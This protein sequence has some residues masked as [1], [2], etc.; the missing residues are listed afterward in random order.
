M[1]PKLHFTV[2]CKYRMVNNYYLDQRRLWNLKHLSESGQLDD[3]DAQTYFW[4]QATAMYVHSLL[5]KTIF[6]LKFDSQ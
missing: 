2:K 3:L 5:L 6:A 4:L 1:Q